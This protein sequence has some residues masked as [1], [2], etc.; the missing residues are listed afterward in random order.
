MMFNSPFG[1]YQYFKVPFG[2]AQAPA[3][4]QELMTGIVKD[5]D[6]AIAYLDD[7]IIFSTTAEE[8]LS[9]I[10]PSFSEVMHC[11][12][13]NEV[14]QMSFLYEGNTI[15]RTHLQ[16]QGHSTITIKNSSHPEHA[17]TQNAQTSS[18]PSWFSRILQKS[19]HK[20]CQNSQTINTPDMPTSKI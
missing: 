3:Y 16:H 10:K 8:H 20:L 4:F 11:K 7:I 15:P 1:K 9:H 17:S 2:L 5:F 18:H 6:F 19:Y 14:Q 13:L 12:T